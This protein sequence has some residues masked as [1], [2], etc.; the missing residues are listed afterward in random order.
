MKRLKGSRFFAAA[1]LVLLSG[2]IANAQ[3]WGGPLT[4]CVQQTLGSSTN[5][6]KNSSCNTYS[7]S[8]GT[9]TGS[10]LSFG[11]SQNKT[12]T[13]T[14]TLTPG[15]CNQIGGKWN[16]VGTGSPQYVQVQEPSC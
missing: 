16:C 7:Y 2:A 4:T 14:E 8:T 10:G 13:V 1:S 6:S 9:C 15:Y 5:C 12:V 11:C 3:E